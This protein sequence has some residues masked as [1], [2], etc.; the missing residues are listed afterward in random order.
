[1]PLDAP[2]SSKDVDGGL[3]GFREVSKLSQ[4]PGRQAQCLA[5]SQGAPRP[6]WAQPVW[7]S[8][9][10]PHGPSLWAPGEP[11]GVSERPA[12]GSPVQ[13]ARHGVGDRAAPTGAPQRPAVCMRSPW[14]CHLYPSSGPDRTDTGGF[15]LGLLVLLLFESEGSRAWACPTRP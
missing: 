11:F 5:R 8:V 4:F 6:T 1:M 10:N 14:E 9:L 7:P 12:S 15:A 2:P 3:P 13:E